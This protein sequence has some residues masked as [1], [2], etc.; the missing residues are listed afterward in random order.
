MKNRATK[1]LVPQP[2]YKA[3]THSAIVCVS[4]PKISKEVESHETDGIS[5]FVYP[6]PQ[7]NRESERTGRNMFLDWQTS[8]NMLATCLIMHRST[9]LMIQL[10]CRIAYLVN[11]MPT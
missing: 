10:A 11:S 5:V 3:L 6:L 1:K 7:I 4:Y 2:C 9:E 8:R